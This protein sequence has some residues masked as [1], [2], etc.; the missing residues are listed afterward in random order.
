[1]VNVLYIH[2]CVCVF[3]C[4]RT[5]NWASFV[6]CACAR[7]RRLSHRYLFAISIAFPVSLSF[8]VSSSWSV[9]I[10]LSC[11]SLGKIDGNSFDCYYYLMVLV[12]ST[13]EHTHTNKHIHTP[14]SRHK[15]AT[16]HTLSPKTEPNQT[17]PNQAKSSSSIYDEAQ[18]LHS[19]TGAHIL[20][21]RTCS[22]DLLRARELVCGKW[23]EGWI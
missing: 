11:Y 7:A 18:A 13:L 19:G 21:T 17:K 23:N 5:T 2:L 4:V 22:L 14:H 20:Y 6:E 3:V 10:L 12:W 1:M 9:G 8:M 15:H 16:L